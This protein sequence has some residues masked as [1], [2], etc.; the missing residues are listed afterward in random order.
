MTNEELW[1]INDYRGQKIIDVCNMLLDACYERILF[2]Y[3]KFTLDN[4]D[5]FNNSP[6]KNRPSVQLLKKMLF[7][8]DN[9]KLFF[10]PPF[11]KNYALRV[12]GQGEPSYSMNCFFYMNAGSENPLILLLIIALNIA[13]RMVNLISGNKIFYRGYSVLDILSKCRSSANSSYFFQSIEDSEE[14]ENH[15]EYSQ[16]FNNITEDVKWFFKYYNE[17]LGFVNSEIMDEEG[18]RFKNSIWL[19]DFVL[20]IKNIL[21]KCNA[22]II[23]CNDILHYQVLTEKVNTSLYTPEST[24]S[25]FDSVINLMLNQTLTSLNLKEDSTYNSG[26]YTIYSYYSDDTDYVSKI[27]EEKSIYINRWKDD[28]T[29][30]GAYGYRRAYINNLNQYITSENIQNKLSSLDLLQYWTENQINNIK[31]LSLF[32]LPYHYNETNYDFNIVNF[33]NTTPGRSYFYYASPLPSSNNGNIKEIIENGGFISDFPD[34]EFSEENT[35]EYNV[36]SENNR[37][38]ARGSEERILQIDMKTDLI[39]HIAFKYS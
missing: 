20:L 8:K 2:C 26:G 36:I 18:Y 30:T 19:N 6:T 37:E 14:R 7:L 25:S 32:C 11:E 24:I 35:P 17:S 28:L 3:P 4:N 12:Y 34:P 33:N 23:N 9:K 38:I 22:I 31:F 16:Y 29:G 15:T 13:S 27:Y 10:Y 39:L 5:F 21:K 1:Q